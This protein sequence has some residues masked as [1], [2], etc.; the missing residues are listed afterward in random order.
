[1]HW[2]VA[3]PMFYQSNIK[4]SRWIDDFVVSD[5]HTFTKIPRDDNTAHK[6]WHTR[7]SRNTP[8]SDWITFWNQSKESINETKGGCITVFPQLGT[9]VGLQKRLRNKSTPILAWCFNVGMLYP[10]IKQSLAQYSLHSVDHFVV[11]SRQECELVSQWLNI[12]ASRFEFVPLQRAEIPAI[13][14]EDLENPFI[15]S[16]GSANRDYKTFFDAVKKLNI[17]TIVV[18]SRSALMGLEI[19]SNVEIL[20]GLN[21]NQCL[22]LA[23]KA[24]LNVVPLIDHPTAAGQVTVVEAMRMSRPVI[25][26]KCVGTEDYIETGNTGILVQPYAVDEL[27]SAL[28]HT[29]SDESYRRNISTKAGL[30]AERTFSD[31]SAGNRLRAILDRLK[32]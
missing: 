12:P 5:E 29:W 30:Y 25:A 13:S 9:M 1:M 11:H 31:K 16:M 7:L 23:Q 15:L 3:A 14:S 19:P 18:A 27:A 28:H 8:L 6:S 22:E 17:R 4:D 26:T 20:S 10:G 2:T 32:G 24:R 21:H